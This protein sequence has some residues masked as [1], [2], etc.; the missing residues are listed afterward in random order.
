MASRGRD[1]P[2]LYE[3]GRFLCDTEHDGT[4]ELVIPFGRPGDQPLLG[5]PAG[6]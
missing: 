5:D 4:T 6:L 3:E 2:C 1:D